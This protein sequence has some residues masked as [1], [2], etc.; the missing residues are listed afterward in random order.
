MRWG[1]YAA[2]GKRVA[3]F[4]DERDSRE[5]PHP[6][7]HALAERP[8]ACEPIHQSVFASKIKRRVLRADTG[9]TSSPRRPL[10]TGEWPRDPAAWLAIPIAPALLVPFATI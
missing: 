8:R 4:K 1:A 7:P 5:V 2:R 9:Q 10:G 6:Y 3:A